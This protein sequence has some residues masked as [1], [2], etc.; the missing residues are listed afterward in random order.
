MIRKYFKV[1][2][3]PSKKKKCSPQEKG[4]HQH[5]AVSDQMHVHVSESHPET[6]N[7]AANDNAECEQRG[8]K[9]GPSVLIDCKTK[10]PSDPAYLRGKALTPEVIRELLAVGPCQPGLNN[11][12]TFQK[13]CQSYKDVHSMHH[14]I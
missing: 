2:E 7:Q 5:D 11:S 6:P 1:E 13:D 4:N 8:N 14:G 12:F 10:Y 9:D 3:Q